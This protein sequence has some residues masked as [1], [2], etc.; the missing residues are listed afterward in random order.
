M[1]VVIFV[2][3]SVMVNLLNVPRR[4]EHHLEAINEYDR[5]T[6]LEN[7]VFILPVATMVE[8]GNH[9]AHISD[10]NSRF[11]IGQKFANLIKSAISM[12]ECW[13]TASEIPPN[14]LDTGLDIFLQTVSGGEGFGDATIIA[15]FEEYWTKQ[16][17]IGTMRIWSFDSHLQGFEKEGGLA[18]RKNR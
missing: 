18:R 1:N 13:A 4:N 15:Q 3:T 8:T 14:V 2:D 17:P 11:L 5:L 16:Q 7:A 9:I 6:K 10:G 12:E